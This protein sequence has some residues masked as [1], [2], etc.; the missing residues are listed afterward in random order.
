MLSPIMKLK[1]NSRELKETQG[2]TRELK[3]TQGNS[4]K[5]KGL[6]EIKLIWLREP[7]II[8]RKRL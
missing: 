4:R 2:D 6:E 1:G 3:E 8:Q 5:L 7:E